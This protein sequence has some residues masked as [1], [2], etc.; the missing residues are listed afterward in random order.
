MLSAFSYH[1]ISNSFY[2]Y[3]CHT[4][5][6]L[7]ITS[8]D[9]VVN[10]GPAASLEHWNTLES[11]SLEHWNA[12]ES[13]CVTS[14]HLRISNILVLYTNIAISNSITIQTCVRN[15]LY[16]NLTTLLPL[17]ISNTGT[18]CTAASVSYTVHVFRDFGY[19][20]HVVMHGLGSIY[21]ILN[22][23]LWRAYLF[24]ISWEN[25]NNVDCKVAYAY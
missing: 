3:L 21:E 17:I 12:L 13:A 11:A 25:S 14:P 16:S 22:H 10:F 7:G 5:T 20:R 18:S 1:S 8:V 15:S 2:S 19:N 4:H 24:I 6:G 23:L 9:G